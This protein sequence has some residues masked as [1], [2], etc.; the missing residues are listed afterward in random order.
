[1]SFTTTEFLDRV[2]TRGGIPT[3][4]NTLTTAR[5][6]NIGDDGIR[7]YIL[8]L[9]M[10]AR[11]FYYA[12][13]DDRDVNATG[14][15]DL[16]SRAVAGKLINACLL[17]GTSRLDLAWVTEEELSVTDTPVSGRPGMYLKRNQLITVPIAL[18]FDTLRMT[19][20]IRPGKLVPTTEAA[21]I[22]AINTATKTLTFATG[23]IPSTFTTSVLFDIIQDKPH[24]DHLSI[25]QVV[26][27]VTTT[28]MV[29]SSTLSS[30]LVVGDWVSLAGESPVVQVPV[31]LQPL[32]VQNTANTCLRS[33]NDLEALAAGEKELARMEKD[34]VSLYNPRIETEG[35]K[36]IMRS[37]ILRRG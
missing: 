30:R 28:T 12:Y 18:G 10:K 33:Q 26:T 29:F 15:Y 32:L 24:F 23:T 11:E 35:K 14:V 27:S 13:D 16:H 21:Q 3:N 9:I 37:G 1:M 19:I 17:S 36:I 22:T 4:Q 31:E 5:L 20:P 2:K 7:S 25:D 6:L 34:T 8:P